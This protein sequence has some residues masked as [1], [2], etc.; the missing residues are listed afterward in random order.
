MRTICGP[1]NI[2]GKTVE[3]RDD[4]ICHWDGNTIK[5]ATKGED[6]ADEI[7]AAQR[8]TYGASGITF[9]K[10]GSGV[11]PGAVGNSPAGKCLHWRGPF[12]RRALAPLTVYLNNYIRTLERIIGGYS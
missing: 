10:A 4:P 7:P 12:A 6:G 11:V 3:I 9:F 1:S 8:R 5:L 2:E